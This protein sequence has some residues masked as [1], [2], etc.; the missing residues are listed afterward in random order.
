WSRVCAPGAWAARRTR[1][2]CWS[3]PP[4][5]DSWGSRAR[6]ARGRTR[7]PAGCGGRGAPVVRP[8]CLPSLPT[9]VLPRVWAG[10]GSRAGR[11]PRW[12]ASG[13]RG[14]TGRQ[15]SL[16]GQQLRVAA[17]DRVLGGVVAVGRRVRG[18]FGTGARGRRGRGRPV[19]SATT[20]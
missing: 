9:G 3:S 7:P 14:E 10:D 8:A 4:G 18:G 17:D 16:A 5:S 20:G 13:R 12:P 6:W 2:C 15:G 1:S 19:L 11:G